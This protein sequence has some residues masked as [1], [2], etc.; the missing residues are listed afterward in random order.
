MNLTNNDY[1][2][3]LLDRKEQM[4]K[5]NV[6]RSH[7]HNEYTEQVNKVALTAKDDKKSDFERRNSYLSIW[8]L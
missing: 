8:S 4:R 7:L 2:N 3:C 6:I 5:M 1:K